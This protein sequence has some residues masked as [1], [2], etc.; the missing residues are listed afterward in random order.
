RPVLL[1]VLLS[2]CD[3]MDVS[4]LRVLD[5]FKRMGLL[6]TKRDAALYYVDQSTLFVAANAV[7]GKV[8]S[9][10]EE[11]DIQKSFKPIFDAGLGSMVKGRHHAVSIVTKPND[12]RSWGDLVTAIH[13]GPGAP[14]PRSFYFVGDCFA[15]LLHAQYPLQDV[16]GFLFNDHPDIV[17]SLLRTAIQTE[18]WMAVNNTVAQTVEDVGISNE[19]K[20]L[21]VPTMTLSL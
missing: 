1:K 5:C 10:E 13:S 2:I 20:Q 21:V 11:E 9:P 12:K 4:P 8:L 14:T 17:P 16:L 15:P 6:A 18:C 7:S 3:F 19:L